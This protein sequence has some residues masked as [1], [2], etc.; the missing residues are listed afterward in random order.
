[1]IGHERPKIIP[2][3]DRQ[4]QKK[5]KLELFHSGK[6]RWLIGKIEINDKTIKKDFSIHL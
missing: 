5:R 3:K 1:M 4:I 2:D 6:K